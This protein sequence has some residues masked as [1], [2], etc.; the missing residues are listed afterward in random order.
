MVLGM[1][2]GGGVCIGTLADLKGDAV[3]SICE[4]DV[5]AV[6]VFAFNIVCGKGNGGQDDGGG[7]YSGID[8]VFVSAGLVAV[9]GAG[10]DDDGGNAVGE[11]DLVSVVVLGDDG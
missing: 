1:A 11:D 7:A 6:G 5:V 8:G 3:L 2:S 4:E 9:G 10:G